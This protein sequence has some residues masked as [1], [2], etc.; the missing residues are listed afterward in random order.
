M[1][2]PAAGRGHEPVPLGRSAADRLAPWII[3]PM[4]YLATLA[5]M[6]SLAAAGAAGTW[7]AALDG[8]LTVQL[9]LASETEG[10]VEAAVA[11]LQDLPEV[12]AARALSAAEVTALL[13]PWLGPEETA[14]LAD[15]APPVLIDVRLA[16]RPAD[17]AALQAALAEAVPGAMV[18][19][20][21]RWLTPVRDLAATVRLVAWLVL[22][23]A[24][25][26]TAATVIA[27]TAAALTVHHRT[28]ELLHALG[29]TDGYVAGL[30]QRFAVRLAA[31]GAAV[32]M[33][34][35]VVT[36][37]ALGRAAGDGVLPEAGLGPLGW[38]VLP[39]VPA[40]AAGLALLAARITVLRTLARW[41]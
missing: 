10:V 26:A 16:Q 9:P 34:L 3:V 21:G 29:A 41:P 7:R 39:A 19:G 5:L 24:T 2:L 35:A 40:A 33:A 23:V 18:A 6:A 11:A 8:R 30:F 13:E 22:G 28:V 31:V 17:M 38:L 32:G 1:R 15:L 4:A 25:A 20:H 14:V 27:V 37:V 12:A 36:L